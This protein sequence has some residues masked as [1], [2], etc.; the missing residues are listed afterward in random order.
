MLVVHGVV[1]AA[2]NPTSENRVIR[3]GIG[4]RDDRHVVLAISRDDV[5]FWVFAELFR[6]QLGCADALYLDGF[7]SAQWVEAH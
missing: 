4:L 3:S 5:S 2:F 6:R 7:I 1:N